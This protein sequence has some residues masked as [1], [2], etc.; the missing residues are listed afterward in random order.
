MNSKN[1]KKNLILPIWFGEGSPQFDKS[2]SP[3]YKMK[4][5]TYVL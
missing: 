1:I 3:T 4:A 5:N 2:Y